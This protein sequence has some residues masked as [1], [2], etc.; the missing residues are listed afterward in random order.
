MP[1]V[2]RHPLTH[3]EV[4]VSPERSERPGAWSQDSAAGESIAAPC[5]FCP[6]NEDQTPP[7]IIR[8]E[9]NG[10]WTARVVPN[11]Y[12][13]TAP[14][15]GVASHE[16]LIDTALHE[17][18]LRDRDLRSLSSTIRLW[19][20]R[21]AMHASRECVESVIFFRNEGR[22]AGQSIAHPHSQLIALPFVTPRLAAELQS[23]TAAPECPLCTTPRDP[24]TERLV[25]ERCHGVTLRCPSAPRFPYEVWIIPDRHEPDWLAC[26]GE[27]L[28]EAL[29]VAT[30][31]LDR[32][33]PGAAFNVTLSSTPVHVPKRDRFHWHIELL[34]RLTNI[35]G[36]ELATGSWLN[37][38]DAERAASELRAAL[39]SSSR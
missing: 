38:V 16:V 31:A 7:E 6:G 12:P 11:L 22:A 2:S 32:R 34:P 10:A 20:E 29:Q 18:P 15:N 36:F 5:P 4:L 8:R 21:Y 3:E 28:A 27:A 30:R 39:T 26:D 23:F 35:A 1:S 33:W 13:A 37:I 14:M 19:K 9:V 17:A 24:S 25:V